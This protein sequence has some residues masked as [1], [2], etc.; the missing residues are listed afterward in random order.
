V[1]ITT[2][3]GTRGDGARCR[4]LAIRAYLAK[5]V[6]RRDLLQAIKMVFGYE[7]QSQQAA[8]L[9]TIH[10]LGTRTGRLK[11]L[12]VEDNPVN[13]TLAARLL[14]QRG[15][16]V[17]I[18]DNGK[19]ALYTLSREK[20]DVV[21]MDVQM[22]EMD[23]FEATSAIRERERTQGGRIPII[24]MTAHAMVGDKQRCLAAGMDGYVSKPLRPQELFE[25]LEKIPA[26]P[27]SP[28]V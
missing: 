4:E 24:A 1:I 14:E 10:S 23:G 21:L 22:P 18:A 17:T 6:R 20:F 13:Q 12:L 15:H 5:P 8:P 2:S 11:V 16:E 25:M 28:V 19:K 27:T 3:A 9:V 26:G 7:T